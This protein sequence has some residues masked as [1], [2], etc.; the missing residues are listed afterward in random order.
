MNASPSSVLHPVDRGAASG[1]I[2][3]ILAALLASFLVFAAMLAL[4][5]GGDDTTS[6]VATE[7]G[8]EAMADAD[9]AENSAG[10]PLP[11]GLQPL[12]LQG[13]GLV[14]HGMTVAEAEAVLAATL[15]F[16]EPVSEGCYHAWDP[17][18]VNSPRFM[19]IAST[20]EPADGTIVRIELGETHTT[21]SGIHIGSTKAEVLEAYGDRIVASPHPYGSGPASEY[22]TYVPADPADAGYRLIMETEDDRVVA[23]RSGRLPEVEWI[24]GCA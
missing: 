3:A 20:G 9:D 12:T 19:V 15:E 24:E 16:G 4:L 13:M 10:A 7:G 21:R 2:V 23:I 17:T 1:W 8:A 6:A 5:F 11:T 18:D 14:E 22:L